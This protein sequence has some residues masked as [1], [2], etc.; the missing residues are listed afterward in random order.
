MMGKTDRSARLVRFGR[1]GPRT[2][3]ARGATILD[4]ARQ[5][6]FVIDSLCGG[7]SACGKCR[8]I[9]REGKVQGGR[10]S[11]LTRE[12]IQAGYVLACEARVESD[13]IVEV[14]PEFHLHDHV[15]DLEAQRSDL[16]AIVAR[17]GGVGARE[18]LVRRIRL[19]VPPPTLE[20]NAA[21]L[22]RLEHALKGVL[23]D[24]REIQVGLDVIRTLPEALRGADGDATATIARRGRG[25]EILEVV[26]GERRARNLA[27]AVDVGTT[28]L[29]AELLDL[30][31]GESLATAL[32]YNSQAA[33]GADVIRRIIWCD[34]HDDGLAT[35]RHLIASDINALIGELEEKTGASAAQAH[36]VV[37]AGNT[38]M[39]HLLLGLPPR[40]IRREPYAGAAH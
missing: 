22:E 9:V 28:T 17:D 3:A 31:S 16:E 21:D 18:P 12:E 36:A 24:N 11:L 35:L 26:A 2:M 8:V 13:L 40:W 37:A 33:Y 14:P 27:V 25:Y 23:G 38:T 5:A 15:P 20:N 19:A 4:A 7:E 39:M 1:E 32:R 10:S 29:M 30:S 6:G 34:T